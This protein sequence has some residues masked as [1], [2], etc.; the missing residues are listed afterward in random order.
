MKL[1]VHVAGRRRVWHHQQ[2]PLAQLEDVGH[3]A[4]SVQ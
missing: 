2:R 3:S 4:G 1:G